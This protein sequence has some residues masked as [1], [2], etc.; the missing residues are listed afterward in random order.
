MARLIPAVMRTASSRILLDHASPR[1]TPN[2][3]STTTTRIH[4]TAIK[5]A[6][7]TWSMATALA[8]WVAHEGGRAPAG[9]GTVSGDIVAPATTD[10]ARYPSTRTHRHH[11]ARTDV[12]SDTVSADRLKLVAACDPHRCAR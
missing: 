10:S 1:T 3:A 7:P 4:D 12:A 2:A 11:L 6:R 9:I 5:S 8:R